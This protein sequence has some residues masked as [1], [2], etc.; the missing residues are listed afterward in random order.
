[1]TLGTPPGGCVGNGEFEIVALRA[2]P[3]SA[4]AKSEVEPDDKCE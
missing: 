2:E 4:A 1:M 3:E